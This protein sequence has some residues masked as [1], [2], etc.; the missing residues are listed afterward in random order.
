MET[1]TFRLPVSPRWDPTHLLHAFD[2]V[3]CMSSHPSRAFHEIL[4]YSCIHVQLLN[5][6]HF[7]LIGH[8][9]YQITG[10]YVVVI[11]W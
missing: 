8:L 3:T 6:A 5:Y 10:N 11:L 1:E 2:C 4:H 9:F 7:Y